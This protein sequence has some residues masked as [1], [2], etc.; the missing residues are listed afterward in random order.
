M[1]DYPLSQFASSAHVKLSEGALDLNAGL[2][3]FAL[4][5]EAISAG[6]GVNA[7]DLLLGGQG[8][9]GPISQVSRAKQQVP[10]HQSSASLE[11]PHRIVHEC[12]QLVAS[13]EVHLAVL[14][15]AGKGCCSLLLS[16]VEQPHV[17][18]GSGRLRAA[19]RHRLEA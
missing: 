1:E 11:I 7:A 14:L 12:G 19:Y 9:L 16:K 4:L 6:V 15:E 2:D 5:S 3:G 13:A 8:K 17:D 10:P 18:A